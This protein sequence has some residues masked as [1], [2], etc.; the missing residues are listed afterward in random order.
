M[1]KFA[2]IG[3][4]NIAQRHSIPAIIDSGVSNISVCVDNNPEREQE[5]ADKFSL[6]F[7][8]SL[9]HAL[10][11]YD[12]DAVY[13][14]T[15]NGTHKEIILNAAQ[16]KKQVLCEKS[17][18][19]T[20][21]DA[22]EVVECCKQ[23]NVALFEGFMYQFHTQH[24]FV[25]NLIAQGEIGTPFHFQA[26]NGFPPLNENDFRYKKKL[27]GGALLDAGAYTIHAARHFFDAEPEKI[28]AVLENE[29]HEV[30]VRGSV[31]FDFGN[32]RTAHLVFGF[33]NMYQNKYAIWGTKGVIT[34]TRAFAL[35]SDFTSVLTLEKQG[36]IEEYKMQP[37][38]HFI[39]EIK[40]FVTNASNKEKVAL[41]HN[42]ILNQAEV[43]HLLR[44]I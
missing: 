29:G 30:D 20:I 10:Q 33:N 27:G 19:T 3:C 40:Y 11:K 18:V 41:W 37:C 21:T 8:T 28:H 7:E 42:E 16:H 5:V 34:L 35:P 44:G 25:G 4:G 2:V 31:M 6:P 43:M 14:S 1:M 13:I 32:S 15:P 38:N 23:N 36:I 39:E 9:D 24:Q 12:I 26:W 22:R 17:I